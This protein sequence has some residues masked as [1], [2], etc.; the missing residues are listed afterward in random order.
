MEA[1][2]YALLIDCGLSGKEIQRR[3]D[4]AGLNPEKLRGIVISHEHRDHIH[5]AGILA[6]RLKLPVYVNAKTLQHLENVLVKVNV[7]QFRPDALFDLGPIRIRPFS[8]PHD[9]ADT[10]GFTFRHNGNVLGLATDLGAPTELVRNQLDKCNMLIL[11]SNHDLKMLVE[12]PYPWP[13]KDRVRSRHGH[14]S[15][16][17]AGDFL[18]ELAHPNL[19]QVVLAHLSETNNLPDLALGV[20][21]ERVGGRN[22]AL[23]IIVAGQHEPTP[24]ISLPE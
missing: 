8:V 22:R 20:V 23:R 16:E 4:R 3:I 12:G 5:G 17:T 10:M 24:V 19:E 7:T 9:A 13:L 11:E 6:R 14:L 2:D 1:D 21:R 15:N 18:K